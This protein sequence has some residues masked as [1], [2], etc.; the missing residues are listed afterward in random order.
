MFIDIYVCVCIYFSILLYF[1]INYI[2]IKIY[3]LGYDHLIQ[4]EYLAIMNIEKLK[5]K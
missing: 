1:L 3:A 2:N 5:S 4:L